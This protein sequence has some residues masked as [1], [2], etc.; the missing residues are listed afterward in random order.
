MKN[1]ASLVLIELVV[2]LLVFALAAALCLRFF[3]WAETN[4]LQEDRKDKAWLQL[5]TAAETLKHCHG[6]FSAAAEKAGGDW[7]GT[8]WVISLDA[9]WK[10]TGENPAFILQAMPENTKT[11]YLGA[12]HLQ[13]SEAGGSLLGELKICWQEVAQ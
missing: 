12:A 9:D 8:R 10:E 2:M 6:D 7:D 11:D 1:K 5:Q 13:I 3:S 4:S